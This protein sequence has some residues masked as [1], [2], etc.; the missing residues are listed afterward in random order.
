MALFDFLKFQTKKNKDP[1]ASLAKEQ[2]HLRTS[3]FA[4]QQLEEWNPDLLVANKGFEIYRKMLRDPQVKAAYNVFVNLLIQ[5]DWSFILPEDTPQQQEIK[6]F[7]EFTIAQSKGTIAQSMRG[8]LL[9]KAHGFSITEK[10]FQTVEFNGSTKWAIKELKQKPYETFFFDVD[11]FGNVVLI[12]QDIGGERIK[13]DPDKFIHF[14]NNPDLDPI[15]GESDL[16]AAHRAWWEKQNILTFWNIYLERTAGGFLTATPKDEATVLS[17]TER[18]HFDSVLRNVNQSTAMRVPA[19]F[20]VDIKSGFNTDAFE[21]AVGHRDRQIAKA[22]L[23]PNLLGFSEQQQTGSLAQSKIQFETFQLV[24]NYQSDQL[25]DVL[26]EQ[27]FAQLARINFG[28]D[29]FPKF[30]FENR[31][32]DQKRE[33]ANT[34]FEAMKSGAVAN[35]E[36]DVS[37]N[38]SSDQ[39]LPF[40]PFSI[41]LTFS[42]ISSRLVV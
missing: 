26:N 41:S 39:Y 3:F 13:L 6:E 10:V 4:S 33:A 2:A 9:A 27:L 15:W 25:A 38:S 20:D 37:F 11:E 30:A 1:S 22:I 32:E 36:E 18:S 23:V 5:R 34:W 17:P 40:L 24:L 29:I 35:S 12:K 21:K 19:G 28:T 7:F 16:R 14:V 42:S 31:T 8:I